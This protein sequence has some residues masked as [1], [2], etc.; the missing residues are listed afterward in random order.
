MKLDEIM[1]RGSTYE[2]IRAT[3]GGFRTSKDVGDHTLV[4][5]ASLDEDSDNIWQVAFFY[6]EDNKLSAEPTGNFKAGEVLSFVGA[7]LEEFIDR[8]APETIVYSVDKGD[9]GE[10][11]N[12]VYARMFSKFAPEYEHTENTDA[13]SDTYVTYKRKVEN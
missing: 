11:R 12:N 3:P 1:N 2:V 10:K 9:F 7:S 5:I 13:A 8:Y 4:F 6:K